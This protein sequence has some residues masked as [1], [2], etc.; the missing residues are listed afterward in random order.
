MHVSTWQ[1]NGV[2][3]SCNMLGRAMMMYERLR[4]L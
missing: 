3:I 4:A 1:A 2:G